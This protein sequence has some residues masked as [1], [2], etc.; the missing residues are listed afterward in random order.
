MYRENVSMITIMYLMTMSDG[1]GPIV[2]MEI[3]SIG[4]RVDSTKRDARMVLCLA[5]IFWHVFW[6]ALYELLDVVP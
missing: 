6:A 2:S 1:R 5:A 4:L 3:R